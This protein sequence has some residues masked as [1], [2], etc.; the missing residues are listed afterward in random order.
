M[1]YDLLPSQKVATVRGS[2][3]K[4]ER[5]ADMAEKKRTR[6]EVLKAAAYATPVILTLAARPGKAN[7]AS[8]NGGP[9]VT[10]SPS[11]KR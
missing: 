6:R 4:E 5:R 11:A 8:G 2:T 10:D 3:G 7:A 9:S 1:M